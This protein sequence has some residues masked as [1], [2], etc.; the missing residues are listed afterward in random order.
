M[1]IIKSIL[2]WFFGVIFFFS[3]FA[4]VSTSLVTA[5]ASLICAILLLPPLERKLTSFLLSKGVK[6]ADKTMFKVT[7]FAVAFVLMIASSPKTTPPIEKVEDKTSV[8]ST[9]TPTPTTQTESM[10][11]KPTTTP[12]ATIT[13]KPITT[14]KPTVS[15][16]PSPQAQSIFPDRATAQG[17]V[18]ADASKE[19]GDDYSMVKYTIDKQM[20][21]YD[22]IVKQTKYPEIMAKAYREWK[23]DYSMVKYEYEKQVKAFESL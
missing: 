3:M 5:I 17:I 10:T 12:T 14:P 21:A 8:E 9:T 16:T 4:F 2:R 19:W 6:Q 22:W 11:E 18:K 1:K 15:V 23:D 20:T 13:T 7:V